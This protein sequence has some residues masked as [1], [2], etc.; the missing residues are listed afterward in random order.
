M[1]NKKSFSKNPNYSIPDI[2]LETIQETIQ[3]IETPKI[4][5]LNI[6]EL[7]I[8]EIPLVKPKRKYVRKNK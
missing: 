8:E 2:K 6:E 4:E 5:E 1:F 3:E 7:K